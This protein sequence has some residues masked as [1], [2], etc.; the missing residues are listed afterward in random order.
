MTTGGAG[1]APPPAPPHHMQWCASY[2]HRR[3]GRNAELMST[4]PCTTA[5]VTEHRRDLLQHG[6]QQRS[7]KS[8]AARR[9]RRASLLTVRVRAVRPD[10]A[11][12][13]AGIFARLS[14]A[15]RLA[16][17]LFRKPELTAAELRY[18]TD[19]D[20]HDHEA[21]IALT[22]LRGEAIGVA[23]FVRN[24]EHPTS[25]D[26]AVEVVDGWQ[27]LGVG[28]LLAAEL[29]ARAQREDIT[30]FTALMSVDNRRSQRLLSRLGKITGVARDGATLSYRVALPPH[31]RV[32]SRHLTALATAG[33]AR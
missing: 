4:N 8:G 32:P 9:H 14:P 10:D 17:F 19:V 28:S 26:V 30:E 22:R 6:G 13:I 1:G 20:H 27:S 12:L 2:T 29:V 5:H 3:H 11:P 21:V 31:T 16:R 25:A 15:S 23:R 33:G 7:A 24:P 18:L